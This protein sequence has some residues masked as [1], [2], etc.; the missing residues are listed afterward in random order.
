MANIYKIGTSHAGL[1]LLSTLAGTLRDRDPVGEPMEYSLPVKLGD[2]SVRNLGVLTQ[3]WYFGGM[4]ESRRNALCALVGPVYVYTRKNDGSFGYFTAKLLWPENEPE[5][6][7][8]HVID[9]DLKLWKL[10]E[11]TP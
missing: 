10:Q 6:Y 2:G 4:S 7:A 8:N 11:Y 9:L 3:T 5:H 1:A